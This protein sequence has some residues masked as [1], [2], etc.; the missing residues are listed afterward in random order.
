MAADDE[1][2]RGGSMTVRTLGATATATIPGIAGVSH[3]V[4]S[5]TAEIVNSSGSATQDAAELVDD[6]TGRI[7]EVV[8]LGGDTSDRGGGDVQFQGSPGGAVHL[9]LSAVPGWYTAVH[10]TWHDI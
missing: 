3:V 6:I 2:P 8:I 4:T 10:L 5:A 9:T 1:F 7:L